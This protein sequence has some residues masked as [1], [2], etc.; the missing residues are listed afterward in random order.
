MAF[1]IYYCWN[2]DKTQVDHEEHY[3]YYENWLSNIENNPYNE[4]IIEV[5]KQAHEAWLDLGDEWW[6]VL[7]SVAV[8]DSDGGIIGDLGYLY[9]RD[10][11]TDYNEALRCYHSLNLTLAQENELWLYLHKWINADEGLVLTYELID[12]EGNNNWTGSTL[13]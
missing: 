7:V 2:N 9:E 1:T 12:S 11:I 4:G 5:D 6:G 10:Y 8:C 13:G 3:T